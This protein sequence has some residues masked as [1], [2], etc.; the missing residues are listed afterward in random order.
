MY[1]Q[2]SL[3]DLLRRDHTLRGGMLWGID[4][5]EIELQGRAT[6]VLPY[7]RPI[8]DC[9]TITGMAR[10]PVRESLQRIGGAFSKLAIP[11]SAVEI[12]INLAPATLEKDGAWLDLPLAVL[13]LQVAGQLQDL[14][15]EQESRF[16]LLGEIGIHGE[17]RR[18]PGALSIACQAKPGQTLI[19]PAGNEKE[20][21]LILAKPGHEGCSVCPAAELND[22]LQ[23]FRGVGK[24]PNALRD[25]I[26]FESF[27]EKPIDFG[28]IR[29]QQLAKRAAVISAA[30]G[31]NLL[32]VGPP[33]EGKSLIASAISGILPKLRDS[34]MVELTRIYSAVGQLSADGQAVTRRPVRNI[35][36]SVSMQALVGGGSGVPTPGEITLAHHGILFL[37][38]LPEFSRRTLEALRQPLEAGVV[39]ITRS[40]ASLEFPARF[41]LVAAM[42]PCPCGYAGSERCYC[43]QKDVQKY[44]RKLSGPLLDRIDLQVVLKPLSAEERF[45]PTSDGVSVTL[46]QTV[47]RA[48]DRQQRRFEGTS[49]SCNAAIPGGTIGDYCQFSR[50]GFDRYRTIIESS[51][52]TTRSS[53]RLAKVSRT[54]ADLSDS[55]EVQSEHVEEAASMMVAFQGAEGAQ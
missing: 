51:T 20:C 12:L 55:E 37:D 21:A 24:L 40:Q 47:Q 50:G 45:A 17:L 4:G 43:S 30:G 31:H 52:T 53:D 11:A 33:G 7:P 10:A 15:P 48:R 32:L 27:L 18:V 54:I 9:V 44:Q 1:G 3:A 46:R 5:H 49:T 2:R 35:H 25:P 6:A 16:I 26:K 23:F 41:T 19:V 8:V 29:G 38:E 13:M 36:H 28:K 39:T 22:V 42:N 34:E 14:P